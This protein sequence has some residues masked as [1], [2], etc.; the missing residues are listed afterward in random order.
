VQVRKED[1]EAHPLRFEKWTYE[2]ILAIDD[3]NIEGKI[4]TNDIKVPFKYS[5]GEFN[6]NSEWRCNRC[7]FKRYKTM[8]F[9]QNKAG[10]IVCQHCNR[11]Y[12]DC[13]WSIWLNYTSI[14]DDKWREVI[15]TRYQPKIVAVLKTKWP[16]CQVSFKGLEKGEHF[17][18]V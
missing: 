18:S 7:Y 17:P 14:R 2:I 4:R 8:C 16:S 9:G 10:S 6:I 11:G 1:K 3:P 5:M 13:G 15:A 12:I